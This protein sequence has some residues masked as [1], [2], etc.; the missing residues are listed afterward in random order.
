M[1]IICIS[2]SPWTYKCVDGANCERML[3]NGTDEKISLNVCWLNCGQY[4][5]LWPYPTIKVMEL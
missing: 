4:G 1:C 5:A 3:A 2:E